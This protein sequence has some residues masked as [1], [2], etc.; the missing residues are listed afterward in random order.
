M[1]RHSGSIKRTL[2]GILAAVMVVTSLP[3]YSYAEEL[4]DAQMNEAAVV[5]EAETSEDTEE[6]TEALTEED[7][8][9]AA[10]TTEAESVT[11]TDTS[12]EEEQIT[13]EA[14]ET[15]TEEASEDSDETLEGSSEEMT[16]EEAVTE[17]DES[18]EELLE[19]GPYT[20][21]FD[22]DEGVEDI[23]FDNLPENVTDNKDGTL[24]VTGG[25]DILFAV[26]TKK[27][28]ETDKVLLKY[29]NEGEQPEELELSEGEYWFWVD[30]N[31]T[32][33]ITTKAKPA[34]TVAATID[35][36][37]PG[38]EY[39]V[40][41]SGL[42][43]DN[44][45][46]DQ[47]VSVSFKLPEG[48]EAIVKVVG[49]AK[50][51]T[52][53]VGDDLV[54]TPKDSNGVWKYTLSK[55]K[56]TAAWEADEDLTFVITTKAE[57][58]TIG[59]T[60]RYDAG[61][62]RPAVSIDGG[63]LAEDES[64]T[65]G[66]LVFFVQKGSTVTVKAAAKDRYALKT[67]NYKD[68]AQAKALT[69]GTL[70]FTAD[71]ESKVE[72]VSEGVPTIIYNDEV[73]VDK[74]K[75]SLNSN[76]TGTLKVVIGDSEETKITDYS[77]KM[78][79]TDIKDKGFAAIDGAG[80]V[81]SIDASKAATLGTTAITVAM[82]GD[83]GTKQVSFT[84]AQVI[85]RTKISIKGFKNDEITQEAGT[86]AA[87]QITLNKGAD[88]NRIGIDTEDPSY[89]KGYVGIAQDAKGDLLLIVRT[90]DSNGIIPAEYILI[91]LV[92]GADKSVTL[93]TLTVKVSAPAIP[94]P[95][96][97]LLV[98]TDIDMTL[99]LGLPKSAQKYLNLCY[100]IEAKAVGNA[101]EGMKESVVEY[102]VATAV[103]E[104]LILSLANAD[105]LGKGRAQKYNVTVSLFQLKDPT[106]TD[107]SAL[108]NENNIVQD[109]SKRGS[110]LLKNLSTRD[111]YYET[112]L[113]LNKKKTTFTAGEKDVLLATAKFSSKASYT[114]LSYAALESASGT[115]CSTDDE[116]DD[117]HPEIIT[118]TDDGLGVSLTN[119]E[120]LFPGKY[121]LKVYPMV[122]DNV[123]YS[124]PATLSITVKAPVNYVDV[125]TP[126]S[127]LYKAEK[128]SA[129]MK[130]AA[131]RYYVVD[132][133]TYKPA[134]N[135]VVWSLADVG[136]TA[137][138]K[139]LTI[140]K[141]N[142]TV[143]LNK[144]YVLSSDEE[145]NQFR[146]MAKATDLGDD[147][148]YGQSILITVTNAAT[149][150]AVMKIGEVKG[151]TGKEKVT[152]VNS[153]KLQGERLSVIDEN[154]SEISLSDLNF[155]VSPKTG[156]GLNEDGTVS[157]AKTGTYTIKAA[158]R[159]GSKKSLSAKFAVSS[160]ER[161]PAKPYKVTMI[162]L[163][164]A[165]DGESEDY[166]EYKR[167]SLDTTT[168]T[169]TAEDIDYVQ[170]YVSANTEDAQV[171]VN[172][173]KVTFKNAKKVASTEAKGSGT[174]WYVIK[175]ENG[176]DAE[177]T[178]TDKSV[179]VGGNAYSETYKIS[180]NKPAASLK[181]GKVCSFYE[182]TDLAV[183][184]E[185]DV[186]GLDYE[187]YKDNAS[188][189]VTFTE[190]ELANSAA[191]DRAETLCLILNWLG[192]TKLNK[193]GEGVKATLTVPEETMG[194]YYLTTGTYNMYARLWKKDGSGALTAPVKTTVKIKKA[195][196][197][198]AALDPNVA[199]GKDQ[200][201][202]TLKFKTAKNVLTVLPVR[203]YNDLPDGQSSKITDYF[204][205]D[206]DSAKNVLV[207]K[208]KDG[209]DLPPVGTKLTGW[210]R[211]QVYG[212]DVSTRN[213]TVNCE[214]ITVTIT[215]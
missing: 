46:T 88:L 172:K 21:T 215:K 73:Y 133:T 39:A 203:L 20:V 161:D 196:A 79:K 23:E 112:S 131:Y 193:D 32:I 145:E 69:S 190:K 151:A 101:A 123:T 78:G 155:S 57:S 139:A 104:H 116:V 99:E 115:V 93:K 86:E 6:S 29:E 184:L 171:G 120:D 136:S 197:K 66:R 16:D 200:P 187:T 5:S 149:A 85:D 41:F 72:Y 154:G 54:A 211:T 202:V 71:K 156:L 109:T 102:A 208:K 135:K 70:T 33:E 35:G 107:E 81:I 178:I 31:Y 94:A 160:A 191:A 175:L 40:S 150:P 117:D 84:V 51:G 44:K 74:A 177:V 121:T 170:V 50:T 56:V 122:P 9:S 76:D 198:K 17:I 97:S 18:D 146:V 186:E 143:T 140:N 83:F 142:G 113:G 12:D 110:K 129:T 52:I 8:E 91:K 134:N 166:G 65:D 43:A 24:T 22:T 100:K 125:G 183:E 90:Y 111:P 68:E 205:P 60:V 173:A 180:L 201:S 77:V 26:I 130:F 55:E 162:G 47:A 124:K 148:A 14:E 15:L 98:P 4:A 80:K 59:F 159:D 153:G 3:F 152:A 214:K 192:E 37:E 106:I 141:N 19:A 138:E 157:I 10:E 207:L 167:V 89:S 189:L 13:D 209:V 7:T 118:I 58:S 168:N 103:S 195:P 185:F 165:T 199:Y 181:A 62:E 96:A 45:A 114:M 147:G 174:S 48:K 126:S 176:K 27:G 127:K 158:R 179:K 82:T 182:G 38:E 206:Y 108:Y 169:V 137:L 2:T 11:E 87:Y 132:Y 1:N 119:T 28:V 30:Q 164:T 188:L 25:A 36:E 95:T 61:V 75:I 63:L 212:I 67:V 204:E 163:K 53:T 213:S 34:I 92:D 105:T 194:G 49:G 64:S 144:N 42:D 128:K 210:I